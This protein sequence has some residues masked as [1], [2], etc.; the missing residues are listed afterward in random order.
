MLR[1]NA[2]AKSTIP[3]KNSRSRSSTTP[4]TNPQIS[5]KNAAH[6][7]AAFF[8]DICG[9]VGGV[10]EDLDLEFFT[11]IVDFAGAFFRSIFQRYLRIRR[12]S[13]RGPGSGVFHGDSRFC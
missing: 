13:R 12:W 3:V 11:G 7:F 8:S 1:K 2:P 5:L 4:P 10:V 6:S 9:F